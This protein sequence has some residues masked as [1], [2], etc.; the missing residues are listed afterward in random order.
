MQVQGQIT[1][2]S[3]LRP[4]NALYNI[5]VRVSR[6]WEYRGKS[7]Q[8]DLIHFDMVLI[9]QKGYA[10]YCEVP[11]D[12]LAQFKEHLQEGKILY[13]SKPIVE[14]AKP[15]YRVVDAPYMLKFSKR[16]QIFEANDDPAFP[17]YVFS[18]TPIEQ[19]PQYARR[20]DRFL[21]VLGKITA[22]SNA[23][24]VRN[25][26]GDLMMRRIIKLQD[27]KGT[28]IDLSL[29]GQRALEFNAEAVFDVGQNHHV[30]AIFVGT[31]MK[32]YKENFKFLSGTSACRWYIN[33]NAIPAIKTFQRGLPYGVTPIQKLELQS[34]D[35]MEQGVEEK[36]L[37]D[38]K[39]VDP[40]TEKDKR[41]Q[42]TVTL[43]SLADKQQWCYRACR[44]CNS[45][46]IAGHDG[47]ECTKATGCSCKQ[48]DWKYKTCFIGADDTYRLEFMFFEKKGLEL[49]GKSAENLRKQYDPTSTPP[50]IA[51]WI[52]H[53]FTFIV[54]V[55]YKKSA[56]SLD[57]SFEVI[58]IKERHGKQETLPSIANIGSVSSNMDTSDLP[59]LVTITASKKIDQASFSATPPFIDVKA[60]DIDDQSDAWDKSHYYHQGNRDDEHDEK[61]AAKRQKIT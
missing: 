10:M 61:Q 46:M 16:T 51:Q 49:I 30:I 54:K 32:V 56:R 27:H 28:T 24:I 21:D 29:S 57:P 11:K 38:L 47:Y 50:D 14:K 25:T 17:K 23:A 42:C 7:E 31:L 15:G 3:E 53:K 19:L 43:L 41:F 9:D 8:N 39:E 35:Y 34:E 5:H 59:P 12:I 6:T 4:I 48:F 33:E 20:T 52:N 60:M 36:T 22:V 40:Y 2:L 55:L 13:I 45:R 58:M 44:V 18:L 26:S 37:F 1:P